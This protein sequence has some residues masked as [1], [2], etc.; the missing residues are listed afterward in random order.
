MSIELHPSRLE[1]ELKGKLDK[2]ANFE[3]SSAAFSRWLKEVQETLKSDMILKA[4]L[5]EKKA[6]LQRTLK[7]IARSTTWNDSLHHRH[8]RNSFVCYGP[9]GA[10]LGTMIIIL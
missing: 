7:V 2:W 3:E 6:Q 9:Q 1:R 5:D 4:T 10:M 8:C